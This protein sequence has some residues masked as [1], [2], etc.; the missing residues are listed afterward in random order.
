MIKV[1]AGT[2]SA[3]KATFEKKD[4]ALSKAFLDSLTAEERQTY[5]VSLVSSWVSKDTSIQISIKAAAVLFPNL[6]KAQGL[7]E[8]A[9]LQAYHDTSGV[10]KLL[11]KIVSIPYIIKQSAILWKLYYDQGKAHV[12]E[13]PG[14]PK[15]ITFIVEE[16]PM[17]PDHAEIISGYTT[18]LMKLS[19]AKDIKIHYD[20]SKPNSGKWDITWR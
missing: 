4:P 7:R 10:Y 8:I 13:Y 1:K 20:L 17:D 12:E 18:G 6:P 5:K 16:Y 15:K 3:L 19:G 2:L 14:E 9:V 11:F